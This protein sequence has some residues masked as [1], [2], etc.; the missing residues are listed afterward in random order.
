MINK[1][2]E[3]WRHMAKSYV[4]SPYNSPFSCSF[5]NFLLQYLSR[6][7]KGSS[8]DFFTAQASNIPIF[9][10]Q[11]KILNINHHFLFKIKPPS[12]IKL[13]FTFCIRI[14][15]FHHYLNILIMITRLNTK[16][17]FNFFSSFRTLGFVPKR[18]YGKLWKTYF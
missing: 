13:Y 12:C 2:K 8:R 17:G 4:W 16:H 9:R 14:Y 1:K 11:K 18:K 10:I 5:H 6:D 3:Q 7:Y 15:S